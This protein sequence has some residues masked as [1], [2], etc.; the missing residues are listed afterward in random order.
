MPFPGGLAASGSKAGSRYSFSIASTYEKFCPTLQEKL[1]EEAGLPE[2]V[3]AV[4]EIIMNGRDIP[5]IF[6]ATQAAIEASKDSPGLVKI[7]AGNY[8][9]RLGKSFIYLHPERQPG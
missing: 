7:S 2:G 6:Q 8:N 3:G 5:S 1:G 4:M 9:G